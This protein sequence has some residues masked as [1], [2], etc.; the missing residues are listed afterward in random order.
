MKHEVDK[1]REDADVQMRCLSI[2]RQLHFDGASTPFWTSRYSTVANLANLATI[3]AQLGTDLVNPAVLARRLE[4]VW[5]KCEAYGPT[6]KGSAL[7][8]AAMHCKAKFD[9]LYR[10]WVVA[11]GRPAD[12]DIVSCEHCV[13]RFK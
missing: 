9:G 12:P 7:K 1:R 4:L 13:R 11:P 2:L 6:E 10:A 5:A 3:T 8:K